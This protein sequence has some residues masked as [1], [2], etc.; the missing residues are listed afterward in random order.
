[1]CSDINFIKDPLGF[2]Q[3]NPDKTSEYWYSRCASEILKSQNDV[4]LYLSK[5]QSKDSKSEFYETSYCELLSNIEKLDLANNNNKTSQ[6]Y[7]L[8]L[9]AIPGEAE[10][11]PTHLSFVVDQCIESLSLSPLLKL[12]YYYFFFFDNTFFKDENAGTDMKDESAKIST[13]NLKKCVAKL[14]CHPSSI[15]ICDIIDVYG[16][17]YPSPKSDENAL[18]SISEEDN[19][20]ASTL[21]LI[22]VIYWKK[23]TR[24]H[25]QVP[26]LGES[27]EETVEF[28]KML[29][30]FKEEYG[31]TSVRDELIDYISGFVHNDKLVAEYILYNMVSR[32]VHRNKK[33]GGVLVGNM[34]LSITDLPGQQKSLCVRFTLYFDKVIE[35]LQAMYSK[36]LPRCVRLDVDFDGFNKQRIVPVKNHDTEELVINDHNY[37]LQMANHTQLIV[38]Q[39]KLGIGKF[40]ECGVLNLKALKELVNN[41]TITY[42]FGFYDL[43]FDCDLPVV[44]V[45]TDEQKKMNFGFTTHA[46]VP[47]V[48]ETPQKKQVT[49]SETENNDS[50]NF[51]LTKTQSEPDQK[52]TS[53]DKTQCVGDTVD[54][55]K[56]KVF[57]MYLAMARGLT[58]N[59][60]LN[61]DLTKVFKKNFFLHFFLSICLFV[62][63]IRPLSKTLLR[64]A[65]IVKMQR[66]THY[67]TV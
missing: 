20:Y 55:N 2:I 57:R 42:D 18:E 45:Q 32:V 56:L 1:M 60:S 49:D 46:S 53:K 28:K 25:D 9:T 54:E 64:S 24:F 66:K 16:V 51:V 39:T 48:L 40:N 26:K 22:H 4:K 61:E 63:T 3:M 5:I 59:F 35:N 6:R 12:T 23:V 31:A 14:Y 38:N 36:L 7:P 67:I 47:L 43:P 52:D 65:K 44:T 33:I 29:E 27:N 10:W 11:C 8:I 58:E 50:S 41:Q 13:S 17:Y 15:S 37:C 30:S 21:P 62:I 34:I 19:H